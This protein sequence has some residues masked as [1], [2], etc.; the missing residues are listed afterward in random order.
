MTELLKAGRRKPLLYRA[1]F[2]WKRPG[3]SEAVLDGEVHMT[4]TDRG[5]LVKELVCNFHV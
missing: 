3:N 4:L 5:R 1:F 2:G